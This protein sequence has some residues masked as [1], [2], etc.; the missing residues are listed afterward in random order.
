MGEIKHRGKDE[1]FRAKSVE[2]NS[3]NVSVVAGGQNRRHIKD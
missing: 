1:G 2:N 3:F